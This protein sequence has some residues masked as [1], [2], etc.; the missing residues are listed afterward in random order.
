MFITSITINKI[1]CRWCWQR[2]LWLSFQYLCHNKHF[3]HLCVV[4][5]DVEEIVLHRP[6]LLRLLPPSQPGVRVFLKWWRWFAKILF[7]FEKRGSDPDS[8]GEQRK[9]HFCSYLP[10]DWASGPQLQCTALQWSQAHRRGSAQPPGHSSHSPDCEEKKTK[11]VFV[12][13]FEPH[14][15]KIGFH[16]YWW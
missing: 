5:G 4:V 3:H 12:A 7:W 8:K 1:M 6:L 11:I 16:C 2:N 9:R 10:T 15:H 14:K 13:V